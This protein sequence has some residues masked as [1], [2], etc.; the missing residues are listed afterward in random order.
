M[1]ESDRPSDCAVVGLDTLLCDN[2]VLNN[3]IMLVSKLARR[4]VPWLHQCLSVV[5]PA[6]VP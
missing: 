3:A 2:L 5:V 6:A 1:V 4:P